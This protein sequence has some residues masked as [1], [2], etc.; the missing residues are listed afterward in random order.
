MRRPKDWK[1]CTRTHSTGYSYYY[2]HENE[3]YCA[4]QLANR[5]EFEVQSTRRIRKINQSIL[6]AVSIE[7]RCRTP[8]GGFEVRA[9][10]ASDLLHT[11]SSEYQGM[12]YREVV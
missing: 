3:H 8:G 4:P 1:Q 9:S 7:Q 10:R 5:S 11:S 6:V 12:R 2:E